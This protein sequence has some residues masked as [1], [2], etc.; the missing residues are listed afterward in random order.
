MGIKDLITKNR[1][2][3]RFDESVAISKETLTE[4][5]ELARLSATGARDNSSFLWPLGRPR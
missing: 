4:L 1:S 3:R 2:Y 5:V